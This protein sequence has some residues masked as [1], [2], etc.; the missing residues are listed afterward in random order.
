MAAAFS[1]AIRF[2]LVFFVPESALEACKSA[3][4]AAG[5]GHYPGPG[6]Y[7]ECYWTAMG[8]GQYRPGETTKPHIGRVGALEEVKEAKVETI[9]LNEEVARKAVQAL[10]A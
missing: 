8:I 1:A 7:T 3:I 4:F 6:G 9:C 10:K 2:K 5:A